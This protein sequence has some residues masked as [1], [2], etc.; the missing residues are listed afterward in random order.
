MNGRSGPAIALSIPHPAAVAFELSCA[1]PLASLVI[2]F[3][4]VAY[5]RA[6]GDMTTGNRSVMGLKALRRHRRLPAA[7]A[8]VGV[9]LYTA[10][11]A[12]HVVSQATSLA[13]PGA[14]SAVDQSFTTGDPGC[15]ETQPSAGKARE[16]N[17]GSPEK[18]CPFCAGY[19]ALHIS[20][21]GDP[22]SILWDDGTATHFAGLGDSHLTEPASSHYWHPRAPPLLG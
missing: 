4:P 9:L 20:V 21:V 1:R 6:T 7:A 3:S 18:K 10:L 16:S 12:S 11:V 13:L 15:H 2:L 17:R 14:P 8:L 19:A 22:V 5:V